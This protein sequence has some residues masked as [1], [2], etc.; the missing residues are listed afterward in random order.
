[1]RQVVNTLKKIE[2]FQINQ[3]RSS[4]NRNALITELN[5]NEREI[6]RHFA[7]WLG[8]ASFVGC[9][10][11][12]EAEIA[13]TTAEKIA[14]LD[15]AKKEAGRMLSE[16]KSSVD[17]AKDASAAAGAAAFTE[18]FQKESSDQEVNAKSWL[19]WTGILG[20]ATLVAGIIFLLF[21]QPVDGQMGLIQYLSS[22]I[23]ILVIFISATFWCGGMHKAAKHLATINRHRA[24]SLRTLKAFSA[25]A[26][27][28]QTK[29]TVLT[30]ATRA[31]FSNVPTGYVSTDSAS[32][33]VKIVEIVKSLLPEQKG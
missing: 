23:V 3:L 4:E 1:M 7:I 5:Q 10:T 14:V 18:D 12:Q 31:V 17:A 26:S 9:R 32:G 33:D 2:G 27:D 8:A 30:E 16:L 20:F 21:P 22:K 19:R 25:A 28:N 29:D 11:E 6:F 15:S 24:L 13:K